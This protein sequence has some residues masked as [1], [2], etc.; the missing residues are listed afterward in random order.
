MHI[1]LCEAKFLFHE[2]CKNVPLLVI[3]FFKARLLFEDMVTTTSQLSLDHCLK[4]RVYHTTLVLDAENIVMQIEI[5]YARYFERKYV[6]Q[7]F[8]V[9][10]LD[11]VTSWDKLL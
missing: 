2:Y 1:H 11:K 10:G 7:P 8:C 9:R 5:S 6:A 4:E 3:S